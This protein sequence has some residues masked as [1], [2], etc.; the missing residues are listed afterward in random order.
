MEVENMTAVIMFGFPAFLRFNF[1]ILILKE[2][3]L[4]TLHAFVTSLSVSFYRVFDFQPED[5]VRDLS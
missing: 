4:N 1:F 3:I 5:A 2:N